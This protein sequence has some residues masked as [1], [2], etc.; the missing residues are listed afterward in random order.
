MVTGP[1][2]FGGDPAVRRDPFRR[3]WIELQLCSASDLDRLPALL[4]VAM[5]AN[6]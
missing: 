4:T 6:T 2:S 5:A 1:G 3:D